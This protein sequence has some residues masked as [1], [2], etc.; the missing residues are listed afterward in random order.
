MKEAA[1]EF[2]ERQK[3]DGTSLIDKDSGKKNLKRKKPT[4]KVSWTY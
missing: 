4:L 2:E 1:A 3:S